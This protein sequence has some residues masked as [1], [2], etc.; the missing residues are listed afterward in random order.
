MYIVARSNPCSPYSPG[1]GYFRPEGVFN[2]CTHGNEHT[3]YNSGGVEIKLQRGFSETGSGFQI[4]PG[5]CGNGVM[6]APMAKWATISFSEH[7]HG[8][9]FFGWGVGSLAGHQKYSKVNNYNGVEEYLS[10]YELIKLGYQDPEVVDFSTIEHTIDDWTS[11]GSGSEI[12]KVPIG[13]ENRN[14]FF[15]IANRQQESY[16]DKIMWG[17]TCHDNPYRVRSGGASADYAKGIYIYHAYPGSYGSDYPFGADIDQE[18]ADGLFTWSQDGYQHPDWSCTQDIPY[19]KHSTAIYNYNDNGGA[20]YYGLTYHDGKSLEN[21]FGIGKKEYPLCQYGDGT[22]REYTNYTEIWTS[23]EQMGDRYDAWK[24]GYNEVFSPYSSPSTYNWSNQNSEIFI[25]LESQNG[26]S[27]T[28]QIYHVGVGGYDLNEILEATPPSRPNL[29]KEVEIV[30]CNGTYGYP[31][32]TWDNSKEP[33][34]L[35]NNEYKRYKV[36]RAV[37][38]SLNTLP[39]SYSYLNTYDDYTPTDTV[40][41]I[42]YTTIISCGFVNENERYYRYKVTAVDSYDD[43]SVQSD[44]VSTQGAA[45]TGGGGKPNSNNTEP[46][47]FNLSQNY[48]NPFNPVTEIKYSIPVN[49]FVTLNVYNMLGQN[50]GS[51]VNEYKNAGNY[52][53]IFDGTNLS[54]G[55]YFYTIEAGNYNASKKMVLIK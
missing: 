34:M 44:F 33:D 26:T 48:P 27:A 15:L 21:W 36:Y 47:K 30:S 18:C 24:V 55:I 23:R 2:A 5:G 9:Y 13:S 46:I 14:E 22:T 54:S 52:S 38:N 6:Y 25:Y 43:E 37:S 41:Y 42:D 31:R 11:R 49:T 50:V 51:L 16:Y 8:H 3:V 35:R 29:F 7:E 17:D 20:P 4:S 32:I 53:V 39:G 45:T 12:L 10:P 28:L 19:Y 1:W 40:S